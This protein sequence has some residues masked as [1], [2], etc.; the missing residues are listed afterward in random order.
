MQKTFVENFLYFLIFAS[1]KS[2]KVD[3]KRYVNPG[4]YV[5]GKIKRTIC[6]V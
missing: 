3:T 5:Y 1:R 4:V 6:P 2:L